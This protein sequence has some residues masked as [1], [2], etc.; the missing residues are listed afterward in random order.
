LA[1]VLSGGLF[2]AAAAAAAWLWRRHNRAHFESSSAFPGWSSGIL[3]G[4]EPIALD[5]SPRAVLILH[6]FGDTPQ[7]VRFLAEF[8]HQNGWTVRAP[9]L[10]GHG[11][12][13]GDFAA[14]SG[15]H[16]LADARAELDRLMTRSHR[17]AIVGQSMGG[18]LSTVL[19][20]EARVDAMVL[21]APYMRL[22]KRA[23]RIA[24]L[25]RVVSM[26]FP[27]LPSRSE[28]SILDP[29]A[30]RAALGRG[31]TTPRLL[32]ELALIAE[33]ARA[34]APLVRVPTLVIHSRQDPRVSVVAANEAFSALG[35]PTKVLEWAERSGHVLTAD[36]DREWIARQVLEW[37]TLHV[38]RD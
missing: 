16:W 37:L 23:S 27:Y 10:R 11:G 14:A 17:V 12:S 34:A 5:A 13:L 25:H 1:L 35:S 9:L 29:E 21:L 26:L 2:V 4:A 20:S 22:S 31:V 15:S 3:H 6:G 24:A 28:Y 8:L 19:A 38:P 7:S 33:Q 30:R 32:N 36:F 18:A